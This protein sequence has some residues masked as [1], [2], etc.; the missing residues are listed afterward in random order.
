MGVTQ[1]WLTGFPTPGIYRNYPPNPLYVDTVNGSAGGTGSIDNPVNMLSL[2]L[3]L[4]AGLPDYEIRIAAPESS[5]LRQEVIFDTSLNVTLSGV[6]GEPWHTF[7]SEKHTSG[8]TLS[9]QIYQKTLG[10]TSVLQVVVTSMTETVGD[11]DDFLFKLV[12][13]TDTPTTPAAGEYGYSG[14][15]IYARL[16]DD[17]SPNLHTI[18]ISRRNFGVGTVGFG[19]L[20][21]NDCVSRYCMINGIS[22]GQSTQ[23]AKTGYLTVNNSLVEYC[24]NGGVGGTGRNQLITCNN[25]KAFRISNDGFN[26]HSPI[27]EED[28]DYGKMVLNG[29]EGSYCGDKVGQSAQGAS[30]HE[31]TR[32]TINGG[33]FN[34]NVSGGMVVIENARCDIHG[35]TPYG[36][37]MMNG[38]MRLGNTAGTIANQ[39]G[40]AWLNNSVG[41]VTGSVTVGNGG[42]VGVRRD[43]GAV[44]EGIATIHSINNALPDIL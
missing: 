42:G 31:K 44:V 43:S 1:L 11:R 8:W 24:A 22:C 29:C 36:P 28:G 10:Y 26:Q 37:V 35:D 27:E 12:Q 30:N 39:A 6:D 15:I 20:T 34:F 40:C 9:G 7:G 41:T 32:L 38:N 25:V 23:P 5:P 14:G 16:P 18:E 33:K 17:S 21:V 2:A 13:N 3:G 4:C 19:L